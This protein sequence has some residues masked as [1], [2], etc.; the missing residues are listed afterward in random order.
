MAASKQR[1]TSHER[2]IPP[3]VRGLICVFARP[4]MKA[5][6]L[7]PS[8]AIKRRT[9]R[10]QGERVSQRPVSRIP[11][12]EDASSVALSEVGT[13]AEHKQCNPWPRTVSKKLRVSSWWKKQRNQ[14]LKN[15][16][17]SDLSRRSLWRRGKPDVNLGNLR[18][19]RIEPFV[20]FY[21]HSKKFQKF[22]S[23][24]RTFAYFLSLFPH[25]LLLSTNIC[26]FLSFGLYLIRRAYNLCIMALL[27]EN[28]CFPHGLRKVHFFIKK[29][30]PNPHFDCL[31]SV[32]FC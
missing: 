3:C 7:L 25:F 32:S 16:E 31:T 5:K 28:L 10:G 27:L 6:G 18:N 26:D 2:R 20:L 19:S 9:G 11:L 22:H 30:G 23:F 12:A 13:Q 8:V 1:A 21:R 15:I 29:S 14:R 24:V 17:R 4:N